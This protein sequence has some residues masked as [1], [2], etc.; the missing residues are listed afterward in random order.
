MTCAVCAKTIE[1]ALNNMDGVKGAAVNLVDQSA[2]IDYDPEIVS[3]EEIGRKIEKL[4]FDVV[5]V[6][7]GIFQ[8][9]L[10]LQLQP[11]FQF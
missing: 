3:I 6:D 2:D 7:I 10:Y 9:D 5:G 1:K 4:G 8:P 11:L